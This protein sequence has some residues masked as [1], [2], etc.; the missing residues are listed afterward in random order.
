MALFADFIPYVTEHAVGAPAPTILRAV[1]SATI[2][3]AR[4]SQIIERQLDPIFIAANTSDYDIELD[5]GYQ[6]LLVRAA[7]VNDLPVDVAAAQEFQALSRRYGSQVGDKVQAVGLPNYALATVFP[8]PRA[9]GEVLRLAVTVAPT[10]DSEEIDDD[11]FNRYV[12]GIAAGA[13]Y[14]LQMQP[15][16]PWTEPKLA[17]ANRAEFI[18]T[19]NDA[20]IQGNRGRSGDLSVMM[21]PAA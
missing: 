7:W 9:S 15:R 2:E 12:E 13:A 20:R 1:K 3:F 17:A 10:H 4:E 14:R 18:R 11:I 19:I 21:R 5:D 6:A 8:T 16:K